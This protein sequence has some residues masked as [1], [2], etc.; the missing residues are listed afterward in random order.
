MNVSSSELTRTIETSKNKNISLRGI[1]S[2][3]FGMYKLLSGIF[4]SPRIQKVWTMNT[5][6]NPRVRGQQHNSI[7]STADNA[8][9]VTGYLRVGH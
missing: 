1:P 2:L 5:Q 7:R 6:I 4:K 8:C 3:S 9:S